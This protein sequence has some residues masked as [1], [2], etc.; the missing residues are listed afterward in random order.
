MLNRHCYYTLEDNEILIL[1]MCRQDYFICDI[2]LRMLEPRELYNAQGF[3]Q[4]YII[5][6]DVDGR[7][8]SKKDQVARCGNSVPPA[9]A[10]ALV[11]ANLPELC[12][13]KYETM[14]ELERD[15]AM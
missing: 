12:G 3:P 13:K 1:Q 5:N 11:R 15:M 10:E 8:Y 6:F 14:A 7:K 4:D 2:T 9:F